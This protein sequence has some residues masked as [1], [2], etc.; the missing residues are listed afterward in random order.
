MQESRYKPRRGEQLDL[1]IS[2]LAF[3]GQGIA[4]LDNFV[5]F[6]SGAVPGDA[7]RTTVT[8]VKRR[9]AEARLEQILRPSADR[10]DAR[11]RHFGSCG[12]CRWQSLAYPVQLDYKTQQVRD[13]LERI[14]G[15]EGFEVVP[16]R[17]MDDPW[18]YRNKVEF[19]IGAGAD[20][21]PVV[22]F[23][24]PGR[25][26]EVVP[27]SE[28]R[29]LPEESEGIRGLVEEWLRE[30]S[31]APWDPRAL[32]GYARHLTV[33]QAYFTGEI[34]VSLVTAP[35]ELPQ[36][37]ELT[38]RLRESFPGLVGVVHATND[39]QA[40]LA[41]GLPHE[42]L[43]GRPHLY[44]QLHGLR[45]KVSLDAFFQTNSRM[46]EQLYSV[47]ADEAA[48]SGREVVWDLYS[49][50]GSIALYLARRARS[51]LGI[52]VVQPAVEDARVNA[53]ENGLANATFLEG[54]ARVVLKEV[55]E[56][57]GPLTEELAKP[58]VVVVDP[59]RAGLAKKVVER[60]AKAGP[61]RIVYVSCNPA[62]MAGNAAHFAELGY[63]LRRVTPVDMFPHTPHIEAV[64]LLVPDGTS[65]GEPADL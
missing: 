4:R 12:G 61:K 2:S 35:G 14:G 46:A 41:S 38:D 58:D 6:V 32:S 60:I 42:T 54:D 3:G 1:E 55:L 15:L 11:C 49:G 24:P 65:R 62:T 21:L 5:V 59:P 36:P 9:F 47:A 56:G 27:L 53:R 7:V 10:V 18:R 26:D 8:K 39:R 45:F 34:L 22:G 33:R 13:S 20:G 29:F 63:A 52:E 31:L 40:E 30:K 25:W 28:C 48:L 19:S 44:E 50:I 23:R 57:R 16:I 64:G 17:G 51:V 37:G 43:W